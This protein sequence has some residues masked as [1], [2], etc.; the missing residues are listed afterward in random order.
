MVI[1][2]EN[3]TFKH[4]RFRRAIRVVREDLRARFARFFFLYLA[5]AAGQRGETFAFAV[6]NAWSMNG[7]EWLTDRYKHTIRT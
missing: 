6:A 1:I 2:N 4:E 7:R 3:E 5:F